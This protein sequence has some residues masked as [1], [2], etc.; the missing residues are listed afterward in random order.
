MDRRRFIL[1]GLALAALPGP[2]A[3]EAV[4]IVYNFRSGFVGWQDTRR[5]R[6]KEIV[7]Y[8]TVEKPGTIVIDTRSRH[9]YF[10]LPG[11]RAIRYGVGVGRQ[12]FEWSGVATVGLKKVWPEWRP[13]P[14]MI[15]R[16]L[17]QYNRQLPE[18]M[19]GGPANPLGARAMYLYQ[20][21]RDTLYR[22][23]G[24]NQPNTI[25]LAV[26]SGCIRMLNEEVID[27]YDRVQMG[28]KVIV[29]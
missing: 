17:V 28:A 24:T 27:L 8:R 25:G 6:G 2:A 1:S 4:G 18:V 9:L 23:H 15:E 22:I 5:Y 21:G 16:E 13:P 10:V 14:E 7:E 29:L 20:N 26:S 3:A 11:G 12:G 19:E